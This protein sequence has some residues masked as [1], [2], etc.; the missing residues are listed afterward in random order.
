M[1]TASFVY[2]S[3]SIGD[4]ARDLPI[5]V[6]KEPKTFSVDKVKFESQ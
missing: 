1:T 6:H 3:G 5:M 2:Q 4:R